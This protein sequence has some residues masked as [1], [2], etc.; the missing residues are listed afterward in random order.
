MRRFV[1][2]AL[3]IALAAS[4]IPAIT[5]SAAANESA[6]PSASS[7][8]DELLDAVAK[9]EAGESAP[10]KASPGGLAKRASTKRPIS[11]NAASPSVT[12][13]KAVK[14][15]VS[16]KTKRKA[17]VRLQ[18]YR[19]AS[20]SWSTVV[21]TNTNAKGKKAIAR[22]TNSAGTL[23][24]RALLLRK[25]RTVAARSNPVA[26]SVVAPGA[27]T[28]ATPNSTP[29]KLNPWPTPDGMTLNANFAPTSGQGADGPIPAQQIWDYFPVPVQVTATDMQSIIGMRVMLQEKNGDSWQTV[30]G[31]GPVGTLDQEGTTILRVR[32]ETAGV[33]ELR[34]VANTTTTVASDTYQFHVEND[35]QDFYEPPASLPT[36][37]GT[38]VRAEEVL[39]D[40]THGCYGAMTDTNSPD[41]VSV[42]T[43]TNPDCTAAENP[44]TPPGPVP[45]NGTSGALKPPWPGCLTSAQ[46]MSNGQP[47]YAKRNL[48]CRVQGKQYR[49]MYTTTRFVP[50]P[51][52][53]ANGGAEA[54][55]TEAATGIVLKP[56]NA[57]GKI[58]SWAHPTIGQANYCSISRGGA[59]APKITGP[60]GGIQLNL[61][62]TLS[63]AND[64][65]NQGYTIVMPDYL[66]V[67]VQGP[68]RSHR[69]YVVGQQEARDVFFA[70]KALQTPATEGWPGFNNAA[71]E[72]VVIGHSQGGHAALW[73]G[74]ESAALGARTGITLLGVVAAAPAADL[75]MVISTTATNYAAWALGPELLQTYMNYLPQNLP[76]GSP[77]P[78][79]M[80]NIMTPQANA[81]LGQ[82]ENYCTG[83]AIANAPGYVPGVQN[84]YGTPQPTADP[85]SYPPDSTDPNIAAKFPAWVVLLNQQ[86]PTITQGQFN[87]FPL[88][89]PLQ[90][91]QPTDDFVVVAQTN[92][93]L[94][95]TWCAAGAKMNAYWTSVANAP[96]V[97]KVLGVQVGD[98]STLGVSAGHG[99]PLSWIIAPV[100]DST[101]T[102]PTYNGKNSTM[103]WMKANTFMANPAADTASP[104]CSATKPAT[105]IPSLGTF[106]VP[107][108]PLFP[109]NAS[110]GCINANNN[111]LPFSMPRPTTGNPLPTVGDPES[112]PSRCNGNYPYGLWP[113]EQFIY[114]KAGFT[115]SGSPP[116]GR[117]RWGLYP[118]NGLCKN[119]ACG[120]VA[121]QVA[122]SAKADVAELNAAAAKSDAQAAALAAT[123][124][125]V[126]P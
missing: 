13:G 122:A 81:V 12:V 46:A 44:T 104:D 82:I 68:T 41:N 71:S 51:A 111:N 63:W 15:R 58:V 121:S 86:T 62:T 60:V 112:N 101:I 108:N 52:P 36:T 45:A 20:A 19:P 75:N 61:Y 74:V 118:F 66:G 106:D 54:A 3:A 53:G 99:T 39:L 109:G 120:P 70:V 77:N 110:P 33:R 34:V 76:D 116:T 38:M 18:Q 94:Q 67:A 25:N 55:G 78:A 35:Y 79:G 17:A 73:T 100:S 50:N 65:M 22:K 49:I 37:P 40:W 117:Y 98:L 29:Q 26:V 4:G 9:L 114:G 83:G 90:L 32:Y 30:P 125:T 10:A 95:E 84:G 24:Y 27:A 57:N 7:K 87:S 72:F 107:A 64:M 59:Y 89:M 43:A 56:D 8:S 16:L 103:G 113:Y 97:L 91:V 105:A 123:T 23:T 119:T 6:S 31:H 2:S 48:T 115:G 42:Y 85:F 80:P 14:L 96:A 11:L 21:K 88:D 126:M 5:G 92:A 93:A 69:T 124:G 1:V 102:V 47:D 28:T